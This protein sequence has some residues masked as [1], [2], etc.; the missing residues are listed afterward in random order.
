MCEIPEI[1]AHKC[2]LNLVSPTVQQQN[3]MLIL[4]IR[5]SNLLRLKLYILI[6]AILFG[7][8]VRI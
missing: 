3:K 4:Y 8:P 5:F 7:F 1:S 6:F 2:L